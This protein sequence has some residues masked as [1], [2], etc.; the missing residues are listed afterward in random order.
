MNGKS[1]P[2]LLLSGLAAT[3]VS[4]FA[5]LWDSETLAA[6]R[7]RFPE[8]A[9]LITG[10]FPRH[11]TEFHQWRIRRCENQLKGDPNNLR[12]YDDLAVSQHKLGDHRAA[13]ATMQAKEK[14][15]PGV[16]ETFSNLGTFHIYT[17]ELDIA[18]QY[19]N[20][21]LVINANAH[22]GREKYQRW[23]VEWL[24]ERQR[25]PPEIAN[26]NG[27]F[28]ADNKT[29][30]AAF[31]A[32]KVTKRKSMEL[33]LDSPDQKE[34]V[35][36]VTGMMRFADFDNPILLE[37][38]GDLLATGEAKANASHLAALCYLH[39]HAKVT[40]AKDKAR[41]DYLFNR[42]VEAAH[43]LPKADFVHLLDTGLAKG[44]EYAEKVRQ[45]ELA[46][47]AAGLDVSS[48]FQKKYLPVR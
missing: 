45:D 22:F 48:E 4:V 9:H 25:N 19:I 26:A 14:R 39:A 8:V 28:G 41:L 13:I 24:Q 36:G 6:E 38:L 29:G 27:P 10:M 30:F 20:Q 2:F 16:Y 43:G 21:A 12:L 46:W 17:G 11:S 34:A 1:L 40:D 42:A 3:A 23:L 37:A 47:I 18:L 31:I 35:R 5:C 33:Y 15:R 7:V 44:Q 32:R